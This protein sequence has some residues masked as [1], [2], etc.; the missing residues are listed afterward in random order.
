MKAKLISNDPSLNLMFRLGGIEIEQ[1]DRIE[2]SLSKF[3]TSV[4]DDNL[5]VL[6]LSRTIYNNISK[7]VDYYRE[8]KSEPLIVVI[9]G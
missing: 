6:I 1:V 4:S 9:D 8:N 7:D 3:K 2:E 5:A